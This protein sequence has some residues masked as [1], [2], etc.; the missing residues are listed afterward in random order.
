MKG[1]MLT[2][3]HVLARHSS[4][5]VL[6]FGLRP[7]EPTFFFFPADAFFFYAADAGTSGSSSSHSSS[8]GSWPTQVWDSYCMNASWGQCWMISSTASW[9]IPPNTLLALVPVG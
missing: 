1:S 6:Y 5:F 3:F 7:P 2:T 4:S 8:S 9:V